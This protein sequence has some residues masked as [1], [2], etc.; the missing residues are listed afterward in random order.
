MTS[1]CNWI[2]LCEMDAVISKSVIVLDTVLEVINA[3]ILYIGKKTES[4]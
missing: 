4:Q 3:A 2:D 1:N